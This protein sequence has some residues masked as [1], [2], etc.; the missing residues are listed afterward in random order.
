V[1]RRFPIMI[2]HYS[3]SYEVLRRGPG[4]I[5]WPMIAPHEAR[6]KKNHDQTLERLAER[7]GL[8]AYEAVWVLTD[9]P[10]SSS[11]DITDQQAVDQLWELYEAWIRES[12]KP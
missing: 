9:Q 7:G 10:W 12:V 6:A 3:K 1:S 11:G 5:P 2:Q 8:D 4:S